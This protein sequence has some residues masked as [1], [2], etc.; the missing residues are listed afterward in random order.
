MA[1]K[2]PP[3]NYAGMTESEVA[4]IYA[5]TYGAPPDADDPG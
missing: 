2:Q 1:A 4:Q 5:E 3:A